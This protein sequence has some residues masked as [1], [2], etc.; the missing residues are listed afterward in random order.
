MNILK[1][2]WN[3]AY[4]IV[5]PLI[6]A[7]CMCAGCFWTICK[8]MGYYPE[9]SWLSVLLFDCSQII[10]MGISL[11]IVFQNK[12]NPLYIANHLFQIKCYIMALITIQ[13]S[14]I[15]FLFPA[16]YTWECT[17]L[18]LLLTVFFFDTKL[19]IVNSVFCTVSLTISYILRPDVFLPG[20][21]SQHFQILSFQIVIYSL[22]V[23]VLTVIV[24]LAESFLILA[25][26]NRDK[27]SRLLQKQLEYYKHLDLMDQELRKFRHDI[28]NHFICIDALL[29]K[30]DNKALLQY[31]RDMQQSYRSTECLYYTGNPVTD[32]IL[33]YE[34]HHHCKTC[35][36]VTIYG[37]LPRI[38]TVSSMDLCTAFSNMLTN[39]LHAV[40]AC[41]K[42]DKPSL[43][44]K[45][46]HGK[47]YFSITIT[48]DSDQPLP[49]TQ[50]THGKNR[51]HGHGLHI[52]TEV[53]EKY[54]GSF[55]QTE[56][57]HVVTT[58]LILPI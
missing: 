57:N 14:F 25:Q 54:N 33:N 45:M 27:N 56:E 53:V 13:Y 55:E 31:L 4:L 23:V 40:N 58:T 39:A 17:I 48:N 51:N 36:N 3:S 50:N 30:N 1:K 8:S 10:Y 6:P 44:V 2:Y 46:Q 34:L 42:V 19:Q 32:A 37:A 11:F 38:E 7:L 49:I 29:E 26:D 18:F 52:I 47:H 12:R 15:L 5:L 43:A 22:T 20:T 9:V 28:N 24:H 41:D 16:S 21:T 35:V